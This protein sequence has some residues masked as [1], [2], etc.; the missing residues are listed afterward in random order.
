MTRLRFRPETMRFMGGSTP[1][2]FPSHQIMGLKVTE[3]QHQTPHQWHQFQRDQEVLGIHAMALQPHRETGGHMKINLPVSKD[4]ETKDAITYQSWCW[5]LTVFHHA[6]FQDCALLPYVICSLQGYLGELVRSLGTDITL[7]DVLT[8][9]DE[10][11]NNV[12]ALDALNQELFQ[13]RMGE[14]E[15]VSDW[16]YA[17]PGTSKS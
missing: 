5:D 9:L 15:T 1:V 17:F 16:G 7:D 12:K 10:N 4:K 13:L 2:A 3:V 11:Y 14:N 8:I 6:G